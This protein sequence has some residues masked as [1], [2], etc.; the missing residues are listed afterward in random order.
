[1]FALDVKCLIYAN[2][3]AASA[4]NNPKEIYIAAKFGDQSAQICQH[5][6]N[7]HSYH[8]PAF[9]DYCG[10]MLWGIVRQGLRCK[11]RFEVYVPV[12]SFCQKFCIYCNLEL[13]FV[14]PI[15]FSCSCL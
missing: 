1:M 4:D 2:S 9:C 12:I 11:G 13:Q 15:P 8:S 14:M 7:V 6:L 3:S 10:E 5:D